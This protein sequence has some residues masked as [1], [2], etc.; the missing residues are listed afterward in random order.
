[1][2][3]GLVGRGKRRCGTVRYITRIVEQRVGGA[4]KEGD[5]GKAEEDGEKK[6]RERERE[7][8]REEREKRKRC[9]GKREIWASVKASEAWRGTDW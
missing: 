2:R 1:M 7:R 6:T 5:L 8:E 4:G 3:D 9:K